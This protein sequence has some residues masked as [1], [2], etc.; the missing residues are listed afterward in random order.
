MRDKIF[1]LAILIAFVALGAYYSF[2]APLFESPDE[3]WHYAYIREIATRRGFPVMQVGVEQAWAQEGTQAP[4]YYLLGAP[5]IVWI[6]PADLEILPAPNPFARIGE[7]Q[8]ATNDNRNA[9]LHTPDEAFP[10]RGTALA[11]HLLRLYSVALGALTVGLTFAL[12]REIF[13][14][15]RSLALLA[16]SFV[17][18]LPQFLFIGSSINNDNLATTFSTAVLWQ[19]ART[20]RRGLT[21]RRALILGVLAGGAL[22][23]KFNTITLVPL[24][25]FVIF[26]I[27]VPKR[28][29]RT[30]FFSASAFVLVVALIA[31]WWYARSFALYGD[32][33][34]LSLIINL[35]G[36]R[37]AQ[38]NI[39]RWFLAENEG[40]R[41]STWGVF[42]WMNVLAAPAFYWF[43]DLLALAGIAGMI[44]AVV[45]LRGAHP[46]RSEAKSKDRATKQSPLADGGLL[47]RF[48]ARNDTQP[49]LLAL[50]CAITVAA[51]VYYN[52]A[53]PAAQGRLL[54]P[55][56]AAFAVLWARG[57]VAL[58]PARAIIFLG[59]IQFGV[60]AVTPT[61]FIAPAYTPTIV[62]VLPAGAT[63]V[64]GKRML[65]ARVN[66]TEMQPGDV[67]DIAIYSYVSDWQSAR[68]AIFVHIV[69]SAEIIVAQRDSAIAS[70]N[71]SALTY[72]ALVAD[73][74]RVEIPITASAPDDWR[75]VIGM[76]DLESRQRLGD[77]ITIA[78][79]PARV[80]NAP[81]QFDFDGRATL[82][83]A[84]IAPRVVSR[85]DAVRVILRWSAA[86]PNY[87]VFIHALGSA[88][89]IW[90]DTDA[91]LAREMEIVL[92]FAP[93][94]P[95]GIYPLEL[96]V[97]PINGDRVP[98]FDAR[99]Q[100]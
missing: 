92:R 48:A 15:P 57:I 93:D 67:F 71:W 45:S 95:P 8:A 19:L 88:D 82:L 73:S 22:L 12:A 69:N 91:A 9:F 25:L 33:S 36:E 94:T 13:P 65:A 53:L 44:V 46:E 6:N 68:R 70:G 80:N 49:A 1:L 97:Y 42:G 62:N 52:R 98:V 38:M 41:F 59:A 24:A 86:P 55:A 61:L 17:A 40:L 35:I 14:E 39:A 21:I 7:P 23:T 16:A 72:P 90:A 56:L 81:W 11:V 20:I 85:G 26:F 51:L 79:L 47:R 27:T 64:D 83:R 66:R 60:A 76:Y 31:G 2:S 99:N 54:F 50:W 18:F 77:P 34:G 43:Y 84:E 63:R 30:A 32:P 100:L 89:R 58:V 5:L 4:L 87:R 29:W 37:S 78:R 3:V 74:L 10:W 75:V 28:A 96:G